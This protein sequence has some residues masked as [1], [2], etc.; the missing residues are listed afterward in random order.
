MKSYV[1]QDCIFVIF[2]NKQI[3]TV[4]SP[5]RWL[6]RGRAGVQRGHL[7]GQCTGVL[8]LLCILAVRCAY[9][10]QFHQTSQI[11]T[12]FCISYFRKSL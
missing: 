11:C 1:L 9:C 3:S 8:A 6:W 10:E 4:K 12:L 7:G 5:R 2:Q